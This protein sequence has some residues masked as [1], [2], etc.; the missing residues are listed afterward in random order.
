MKSAPQYTR[1]NKKNKSKGDTNRVLYTKRCLL[2]IDQLVFAK[3]AVLYASPRN[4]DF[5]NNI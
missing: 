1:K 3:S 2:H 5:I 4:S